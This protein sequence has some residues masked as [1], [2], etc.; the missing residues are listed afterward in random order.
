MYNTR[1]YFSWSIAL[2]AVLVLVLACNPTR[3]RRIN[4]KWHTLTGHYNVYFNGEIKFLETVEGF[5]KGTQNDFNK[6]LPV[7]ITPDEAAGKGLASSMDEVIKKTSKS[8]Q[9]HTVGSY[10]DDSYLLMGKAQFYKHDLFAALETFQYINSKYPKTDITKEATAWIARC[11]DGLKKQGEAE[12]VMGLLISEIDPAKF[13][14]K[15]KVPEKFDVKVQKLTKAQKS[16]IYA[17][18]ADIYLK[19]EKYNLAA[20][21]LK[22]ALLNATK[23]DNKIRYNYILGQLFLLQDSIPQA[24]LSFTKVVKLLAP[25]DFEFNANLNLTRTY[26][27]KNRREVNQVKR[28]LKKMLNDDKNEGLY[29]QVYFELA[30]I[31]YADK[32]IP[33]A[34]KHFQLSIT[35]STKNPTQKTQS[36]LALGDIYLAMPDYRKG[37]AYYDSAAAVIPAEDKNYKKVQDKKNVLSELIS[38]I[39]TIETQDSLQKLSK[40][41]KA[42]LNT[43]VDGWILAAKLKADQDAKNAIAQKEL[44]QQAELN[45]PIGGSPALPGLGIESGQWYFYN[46]SVKSAGEQEF[47]NQRKWGRRENEDF[48]RIAAKEKQKN[49]N[50]NDGSESND[51]VKKDTTQLTKS[52]TTTPTPDGEKGDAE[53]PKLSDDRADWVKDIPY[54]QSELEKSDDKIKEAYYNLGSIYDDKIKDNKEAITSYTNLNKRFPANKYE[55]EALYHLYKLYTAQKQTEKAEK[56]KEELI[57]KYPESNF[58]LIIQNKKVITTE[59]STNKEIVAAYENIYQLYLE[60]KYAEVKKYKREADQKYSGNAM[61]AKFDFVYALA[62][63][64]TDSLGAFKLELMGITKAYPKT[65]IAERAQDILNLIENPTAAKAKEED[66]NKPAFELEA[67]APHYYV[68]ATKAEKFDMNDLLQSM[69][70]YNEEYYSLE[71]Y[72]ANTL[73]SNDGYQLLYVREFKQLNA[74]V[75][76]YNGFDLVNFYKTNLKTGINYIQ[77]V[78]STDQF[79]KLLKEKKIDEYNNFFKEQLPGLLKQIKP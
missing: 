51:G 45:K 72:R 6:I 40:L 36:Y 66:A 19:Q 39:L 26:D 76:Y 62:V 24:K 18:A 60:G 67:D 27:P 41:N 37:Q 65:D 74:A 7:F 56:V 69:I 70:N 78:V 64:K 30:K 21:R 10:T 15:K 1:K 25:Y 33:N 47:F 43:K 3:D 35:N 42:E 61:Q 52:N 54:S 17:T 13:L 28:N 29:D 79:K 34:I 22:V 50:A 68:F 8:I 23:K 46:A 9:M 77:F 16:F 58:A 32:D 38:N 12:A 20:E 75:Q 59:S 4:R 11:Y 57:A 44:Q 48:W 2:L 53:K 73:I 63:S 14:G 71:T 55:P 31:E 5:E 49:L